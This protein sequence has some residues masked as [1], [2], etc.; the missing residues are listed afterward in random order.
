MSTVM[1]GT[2]E[3]YIH[4]TLASSAQIGRIVGLRIYAVAVPKTGGDFPFIVYKRSNITRESS[5]G[6]P[7]YL[8]LLSIQVA[9]W[10][11]SYESARYLGDRVRLT[12]DGNIGTAV[13]CT[14][15]DIRLVSETDDFIDPQS[16]GAQLPL[17]YE[18]RQLYQIRWDEATS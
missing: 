13:G 9:S 18:V 5:L 10:A 11:T 4:H 15:N 12:L 6:G 3:A 16:S 2:P 1:I 7:Q 17:A 8:P 14:I